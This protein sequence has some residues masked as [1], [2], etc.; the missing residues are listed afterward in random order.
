MAELKL[1][2]RRDLTCIEHSHIHGLGLYSS[3]ELHG[4]A[5]RVV[6]LVGQPGTDKTAIAMGMAKS[7]GCE[8]LVIWSWNKGWRI[9]ERRSP[10][11]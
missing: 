1:S 8:G 4:R 11:R 3:L 2:E 10:I 6:V 7:L 9:H 5:N